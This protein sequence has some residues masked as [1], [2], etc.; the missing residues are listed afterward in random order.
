MTVEHKKIVCL[1]GGVGTMNLLR[2]LRPHFEDISVV[3]SMADEGGSGGRLRRLFNMFPPGAIVSSMAASVSL[4]NPMLSKLLTYRFPGDRYGEDGSLSGHKLGNL[5]LAALTNING[6][7]LK[8][9]GIMQELFGI[10]GEF[11]PATEKEV[12]ISAKTVEGKTVI[13]EENIDLGKY[14]GQ[15]VLS[16]VFL[17]PQDAKANP[18]AIKRI[19]EADILIAGPGDLYTTNL[20]VLI[21]PEISE[22]VKKSKA[23]KIFIIN[24][25]NKPFET[26]DYSITNYIEAIKKHMGEFPFQVV[27]TNNNYSLKIPRKY[28]YSYVDGSKTADVG[29]ARLLTADLVDE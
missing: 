4:K 16:Q 12:T 2:G 18:T 20:P 14:N 29:K 11:L 26:K 22:A 9:I 27:I 24:I 10:E 13:G 1:G 21:V 15:R 7:F 23:L 5:I 3:F 8:S 19:E 25:A 17:H 28:K 6:D